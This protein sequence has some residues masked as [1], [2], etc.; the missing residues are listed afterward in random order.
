MASGNEPSKRR[1]ANSVDL[2]ARRIGELEMRIKGYTYREIMAKYGVSHSVILKDIEIMLAEREQ[3]AVQTMRELEAERLDA[4]VREVMG[5][6]SGR[7]PPMVRLKAV[8]TLA[9]LI[10][11]RARLFGLDAPVQVEATVREVTQAD[12]ELEELLREAKARNHATVTAILGHDPHD[13]TVM[14][15]LDDPDD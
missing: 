4:A 6:M 8:D 1:S 14:V 5:I 12:L 7:Q 13:G 15:P 10:G 3:G 11:R 9:R 2:R